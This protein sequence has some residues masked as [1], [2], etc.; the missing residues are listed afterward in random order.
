MERRSRD[1]SFGHVEIELLSDREAK[2]VWYR[3]EADGRNV[4]ADKT[5]LTR[6][7]PGMCPGGPAFPPYFL[8][9]KHVGVKRR[10]QAIG[11]R[12]AS[13]MAGRRPRPT[14]RR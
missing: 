12:V 10:L 14:P 9:Q 8:A 7:P 6:P 2:F 4:A 1:P 13:L 11:E 5:T 3:N